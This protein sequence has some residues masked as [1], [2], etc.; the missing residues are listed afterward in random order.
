MTSS[1][2]RWDVG[3]YRKRSQRFRGW[4]GRGG[5]G[6]DRQL[7]VCLVNTVWS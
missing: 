3:V 4:E 7:Q 2:H 5:G 6:K 1:D